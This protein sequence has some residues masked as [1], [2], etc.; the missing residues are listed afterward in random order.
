MEIEILQQQCGGTEFTA[1]PHRL[2]LGAQNAE[3][4][5][6]LQFTLPPGWADCAVALYLRRQDGVQLAPI[7]LD[8]DGCVAVDRRLTGSTGGQWMLAAV[9]GEDYTAY[10]RPGSYDV[11]ATLPT[12]GGS[13]ELPPSQYEQFVA[14]V[15]ESARTASSSARRA[16][17]AATST[18]LQAASA[19]A[20]AENAK[21][22]RTDAAAFAAQ[23]EAAAARAAGYAPS[24][25]AVTSVNGKGGA[26]QL[27][28]QDVH[29]LP[30]PALPEAGRLIAILKV[31]PDTGAVQTCITRPYTL[32]AA[33]ADVLGGIRV[34][35]GLTMQANGV[36]EV[37][38]EALN[39]VL[40]YSLTDRLNKLERMMDN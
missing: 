6:Q 31:D 40:G 1:R 22:S 29:A 33:T 26:V 8:T 27:T 21:T 28:A 36:L 13:E 19:Q 25:G 24:G 23:A 18:L 7:P 20:A 14:R 10:T 37:T 17:N 9:R 35:S 4:V 39:A 32:P 16:E 3:G 2:H 12:D 30:L 5:D 34:G 38:E 15:L 11:Y